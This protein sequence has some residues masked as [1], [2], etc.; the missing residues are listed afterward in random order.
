MKNHTIPDLYCPLSLPQA[1]TSDGK[2]SMYALS[3]HGKVVGIFNLN[4]WA[5]RL[6]KL[7]GTA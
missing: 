3:A 7:Y 1:A 6:W 5:E 2:I 4:L